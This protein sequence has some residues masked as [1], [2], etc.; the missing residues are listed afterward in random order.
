MATKPD[1]RDIGRLR[2]QDIVIISF[3]GLVLLFVLMATGALGVLEGLSS[4]ML[5]AGGAV[6]YHIGVLANARAAKP[7]QEQVAQRSSLD[8]I[9]RVQQGLVD[10]LDQPAL[11]VDAG[12]Q[13]TAYNS[14]AAGIFSLPAVRGGLSVGSLRN[15]ELLAHVDRVLNSGGAAACELVPSREPSQTWLVTVTALGD[16]APGERSA[17]IV[18]TDQAP[19]RRAERARADFLANASHELRTPLT[20][21]SGFIETIQGPASDDPEAWPRF[22]EIMADQTNHMKD[23]IT[24]LLSLS[25]IELGEHQAPTTKVDFLTIAKEASESLVHV[26]LQKAQR[27]NFETSETSLPVIASESELKQVV[28]NLVGNAIK[29]SPEDT[30]IDVSIGRSRDL[31]A[32]E[33]FASRGWPG[34]AR[35]TLQTAP[36]TIGGASKAA[37]WLR[38]RDRGPGIDSAYLPRLGERFFRVDESRGGPEEG[39]GLGLAIVKHIMAHHRGG[40]AVESLPKQGA[41]FSVWLPAIDTS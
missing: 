25:R 5:L 39:T 31:D 32:A 17:L 10:A 28:H 2:R 30:T 41:V 20:S 9:R 13:L 14:V 21:I 26:A 16:D 11:I 4:A 6:A 35:A 24:D 23:L 33:S 7:K 1:L 18:L 40:F 8:A 19:V 37:V 12:A 22:V 3:G 29:Y 15:P 38:V 34:A 27:I 36:E